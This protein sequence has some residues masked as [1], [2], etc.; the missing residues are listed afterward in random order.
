MPRQRDPKTLDIFEDWDPPQIVERFDENRVRTATLNAR[1]A[2][3][4]SET[5]T[6]F[7]ELNRPDIARRMTDYLG[8]NV[9]TNML[10]AYASEARQNHTI[11]YLRLLALI[12]VTG[13]KRL[14]Q[15]GADLFGCSIIDDRWVPWVEV[16][17]LADRKDGLD[18]AY[19]SARRLA[20]RTVKP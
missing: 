2:R 4:V 10:N 18:R 13:D 19:D 3:A 5:L 14:L 17:Q 16:G 11:S 8:E 1:I 7:T 9:T 15:L 20:H 12:H 6:D